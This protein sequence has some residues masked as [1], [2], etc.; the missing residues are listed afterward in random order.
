MKEWKKFR[1]SIRMAKTRAE[2]N[3]RKGEDVSDEVD[4]E[5]EEVS[6]AEETQSSRLPDSKVRARGRSRRKSTAAIAARMEGSVE[7]AHNVQYDALCS[8]LNANSVSFI[9]KH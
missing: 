8:E 6:A 3:T 4:E 2:K 9:Y 5:E 7:D 1:N